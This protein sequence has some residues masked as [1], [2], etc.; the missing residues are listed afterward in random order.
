MNR[1]LVKRTSP[2]ENKLIAVFDILN[3]TEVTM[4]S[5]DGEETLSYKDFQ[6][7]RDL[8]RSSKFI[9][10]KKNIKAPDMKYKSISEQYNI[11]AKEAELLLNLTEGKINLYRTG[12]VSKTSVQLFYDISNPPEPEQIKQFEM[13]IIENCYNGAL[14]WAI[15]Y[16]GYGYKFDICSMYPAILRSDHMSWPI[17][18]GKLETL[19]QSDVQELKY[20]KYG[21]Y[22][23]IVKNADYR[24]FK[25]ERN[26]W[27]THIDLN[28]ALEL[29][30]SIEL[31]EDGK[32]N[33][34]LYTKFINGAK[35]FRP[36]MDY[37]FPFK[38]AGHKFVKKYINSLAGSLC[39]TN[40]MKLPSDTIY[41]NKKLVSQRPMGN[42]LNAMFSGK[43]LVEITSEE[44]YY[45]N[46][47]ARIKPFLVAKGRS[48]ISKII[49]QNLENVVHCHTDGLILKKP[50][51]KDQKL[52]TDIGDLVFEGEGVCFVKNSTNFRVDMSGKFTDT[53][54][55]MAL[56]KSTT[57]EEMKKLSKIFS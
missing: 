42:D 22:H 4:F 9:L 5:T 11:I 54:F 21:V 56:V 45:E 10:I 31:V 24:L 38:K 39:Q 43:H 53:D 33:A 34:L 1:K 55:K 48:V 18:E 28:R 40:I 3:Q 35:L 50:I 7:I 52:G 29:K 19:L 51:H 13:E 37:L 44:K 46:N 26:N 8:P 2:Y 12:S 41:E 17:G 25:T 47:F 49:E 30:Y 32:P 14:I 36:Y 6:Q 23:C 27:Y 16:K 15:A 20:F 57:Y